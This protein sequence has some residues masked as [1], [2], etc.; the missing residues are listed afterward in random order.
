MERKE[1][2]RLQGDYIFPKKRDIREFKTNQ[3]I[4]DYYEEIR[5]LGTF[6][7][8]GKNN[9][10]KIEA[11]FLFYFLLREQIDSNKSLDILKENDHQKYNKLVLGMSEQLN[12]KIMS[13]KRRLFNWSNKKYRLRIDTEKHKISM[14]HNCSEYSVI[15]DLEKLP[16]KRF[17][18]NLLTAECILLFR[19][20]LRE[21]MD[22]VLNVSNLDYR[23][24][25]IS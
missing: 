5:K 17:S 13:L 11:D 21:I 6:T 24:F 18:N 14:I 2:I 7:E 20:E 1:K 12:S 16:G 22:H 10:I 3:D 19:S 8:F 9:K 25:L 4:I 15:I 23:H